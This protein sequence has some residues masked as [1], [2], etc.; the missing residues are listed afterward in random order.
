MNAM[1]MTPRMTPDIPSRPPTSQRPY[2][3][4]RSLHALP[5][6]AVGA[7]HLP[8]VAEVHRVLELVLGHLEHRRSRLGLAQDVV[9]DVAVLGDGLAIRGDMLESILTPSK[10]VAENYRNVQVVTKDGRVIVG[11]VVV[12]GDFRSQ[13]L[14]ILTDPLRPTSVVEI[15]K[16][17]L[18]EFRLT[19][20]SP[21]PQSLVDGFQPAEI[22]DLLAYLEQGTR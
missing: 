16:R 20:T 9:A 14:R 11:R 6:M 7:V 15:D 10:V 2:I 17:E 4:T 1:G 19:E 12:E 21:M 22:L 8:H 5:R 18:E 13:T 3:L